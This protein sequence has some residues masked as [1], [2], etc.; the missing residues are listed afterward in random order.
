MHDVV[1]ALP[2]G[3][4]HPRDALTV[5]E[6][7]H[8]G[9]EPVGDLRKRGG[10]GDREAELAVHVTHQAASVLQLR[11]IHVQVHPVNALDLEHHVLG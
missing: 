1:L 6:A 2:L 3:E 7:A 4:V 8:R 9:S 10:G 5:G 11:D